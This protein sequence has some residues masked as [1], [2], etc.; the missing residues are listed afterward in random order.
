M[1]GNIYLNLKTFLKTEYP[2]F[3]KKWACHSS[4]CVSAFFAI[5][6][7]SHRGCLCKAANLQGGSGGKK[8]HTETTEQLLVDDEHSVLRL[9]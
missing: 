4:L 1:I 2:D 3:V 7:H 9:H 8:Q 5:V 6:P